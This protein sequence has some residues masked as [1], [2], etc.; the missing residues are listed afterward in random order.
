MAEPGCRNILNND[1]LP[2]PERMNPLFREVVGFLPPLPL[3]SFRTMKP[4][5]VDSF[6]D[7][8]TAIA[9][10]GTAPNSSPPTKS[11]ISSIRILRARQLNDLPQGASLPVWYRKTNAIDARWLE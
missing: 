1:V 7:I 9:V 5:L 10:N 4:L 8:V 11:A 2:P 3:G 6:G